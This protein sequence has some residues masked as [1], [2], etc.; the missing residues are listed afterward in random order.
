MLERRVISTYP[1]SSVEPSLFFQELK[2]LKES[3][4]RAANAE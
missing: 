2:T 3:L 1:A 4:V